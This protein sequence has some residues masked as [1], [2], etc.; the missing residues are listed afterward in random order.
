MKIQELWRKC[1]LLL[2]I[3]FGSYP[4]VMSLLDY[5]DSGI[6]HLG[7][8]FPMVYAVLALAGLHVKGK[9]RLTMGIAISICF[10][11]AA[12]L[13][14]SRQAR[15]GAAAAALLCSGLLIWSLKMGGW[16][17]KQEIPV[18]WIAYGILAHLVGQLMLRADR[19]SGALVLSAYSG[20]FLAAL[21]GFVLLTLLSLNR[22][23]LL[24]ASGKRQSVPGAM[25][26]KN[27]LLILALFVIAV[28]ASLLP[29]VLS[30][31]TG[32]AEQAIDWVIQLVIRLIPDTATQYVENIPSAAE[33]NTAVPGGGG[34]ALT[35]NPVVEKLMAACGAVLTFL[36][37]GYLLYRLY[38]ILEGYLRR[39]MASLGKFASQVSED[40]IDEVTDTREDIS[41]EKTERKKGV[42]RL[43][44]PEPR[45][46][47]PAEKI[48]FRYQRLMRKH[49][50]WDAGSTARE[51][52]PENMAALY[53]RARYSQHPVTEEDA[54]AF[55]TGSK[56]V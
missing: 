53:E 8:V 50:E 2:I 9:W 44:I 11:A 20:G 27:T 47:A 6:L 4:L 55:S 34:A 24:G 32:A 46:L 42:S 41:P 51:N 45:N 54:A 26:R 40:Y 36:L 14:S 35:L 22:D 29:S 12:F 43:P 33:G 37:L 31:L 49:P 19:V 10:T 1:Q 15:L 7:W 39:M 17:H 16:S 5:L 28:L 56:G 38:R 18:F 48:R 23:S 30:F 13:L 21:L 25:R 52:L 3:A